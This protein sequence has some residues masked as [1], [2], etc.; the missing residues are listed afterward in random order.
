MTLV[1]WNPVFSPARDLVSMQDDVNRFIDSFFRTSA[2]GS[3]G[4]PFT[5]VVDVEETPA[6][7]REALH[8]GALG[9]IQGAQRR[10]G[11]PVRQV[12]GR[13]PHRG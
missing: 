13:P 9:H 5:P 11:A 2:L 12:P 6:L 1:R 4:V 10:R 8:D 7:L 3:D